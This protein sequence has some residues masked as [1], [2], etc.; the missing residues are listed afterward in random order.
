MWTLWAMAWWRPMDLVSLTA[1]AVR[2]A[3]LPSLPKRPVLVVYR[4][5]LKDP[6]KLKSA[7]MTTRTAPYPSPTC[8]WLPASTKWPSSTPTSTS[9]EALTLP[10]SPER[11]ANAIRFLSDQTAKFRCPVASP[12]RMFVLST[13]LSKHHL[14]LK[15][16]ASW[17][18]F[19]TATS[20]RLQF[21]R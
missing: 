15:S 17:K 2:R 16:L 14:V 12:R 3:T 19:P 18:C 5:P 13:L 11:D 7:A 6:A 8:L 9:M 20:V 1:Y 4:W 10:R 21:K